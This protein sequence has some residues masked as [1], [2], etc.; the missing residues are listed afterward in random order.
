[1]KPEFVN[2]VRMIH[3]N[4]LTRASAERILDLEFERIAR[5]YRDVHGLD[6]VLDASARDELIR[7]GFSPAFGARHLS[8][9]LESTCN[10][11]IAKKV[12][13][14]DRSGVDDRDALVRWLREMRSGERAF[15][16]SSVRRK[17]LGTARARLGY[18]TLR[19]A[20]Q[21]DRFVYLE[22]ENLDA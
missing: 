12:R 17:V 15:D 2:R 21:N 1:L 16:G 20:Y 6:L 8:A 7:R 13:R 4:R 9:T 5:R 22:Q 14:D 3:F 19:I 11:E 18:R 10:V